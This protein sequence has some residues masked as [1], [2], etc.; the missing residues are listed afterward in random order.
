MSKPGRGRRA[1]LGGLRRDSMEPVASIGKERMTGLDCG[2]KLLVVSYRAKLILLGFILAA[3]LYVLI[4]PLPELAATSTLKLH[5][6][7]LPLILVVLI[8]L[9]PCCGIRPARLSDDAPWSDCQFF[10]GRNC[11]MLC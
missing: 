5:L 1:L 3:I 4:S 8:L 7:P 9:S 2:I 11:V 6:F 10:L